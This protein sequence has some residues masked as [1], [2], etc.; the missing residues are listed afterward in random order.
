MQ[1]ESKIEL[2]K[3]RHA[4][5]RR[6]MVKIINEPRLRQQL[7]L[8]HHIERILAEG[9]AKDYGQIAGW[10]H[11]SH[12][13]IIQIANLTLL[14]PDIQKDILLSNDKRINSLPEYKTREI[15]DEFD[16]EKQ[17]VL[18]QKAIT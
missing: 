8:A 17:Q 4:S 6:R 14:A 9:K 16:W 2:K 12:P 18:W 10:L 1:F 11:M 5:P 15:T 7:V 13:R 3:V